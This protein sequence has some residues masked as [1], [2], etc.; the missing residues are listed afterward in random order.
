MSTRFLLRLG[1][2]SG[3]V[4]AVLVGVPAHAATQGDFTVNAHRGYHATA[5]ENTLGAL[6]AAANAGATAMETDLQLTSDGYMVVMHDATLDRTT[7]CSGRVDQWTKSNII[8]SCR[9]D[10]G[11]HVPFATE[12]LQAAH[13]RALNLLTE[14]KPDARGRW[15]T[16]QM[17]TLSGLIDTKGMRERVMVSA[18]DAGRL[19]RVES[20]A[21]WLPTMWIR[22]SRPTV[23]EVNASGVD[24]L[25][26]SAA[27][28]SRGLVQDM[29][30]AGHLVYGRISNSQTDWAAYRSYGVAGVVTDAV[31]EYLNWVTGH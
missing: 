3:L 27:N 13:D 26:A 17:R 11:Q 5:T 12:L 23:G 9:T 6:Q 1:V 2:A 19:R 24:N 16:A 8:R 4:A 15:T 29:N 18:V 31:P 14:L 28:L 21:P 10:D 20:V 30:T 7:S 25:S 22:E